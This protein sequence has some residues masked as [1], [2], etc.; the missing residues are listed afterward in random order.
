MLA[1]KADVTL[2]GFDS[3][4]EKLKGARRAIYSGTPV[5]MGFK[6]ISREEARRKLGIPKSAFLAISFGGSLGSGVMNDII[7]EAMNKISADHPRYIHIHASCKRYFKETIERYPGLSRKV[8]SRIIPYFNDAPL[9][10]SAADLAITRSGASTISELMTARLP[11]I[12]IPSPNVAND[13]QSANARDLSDKGAAILIPE[14]ELTDD[15]LANEITKGIASKSYLEDMRSAMP[16]DYGTEFYRIFLDLIEE[17][18]P[19]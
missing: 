4:R 15:L 14:N 5:R 1:S 10:F 11:A 16:S 17:L 18:Y 9:W 13:H 7:P 12:L 8:G 3:A 6:T 19:N 2:L